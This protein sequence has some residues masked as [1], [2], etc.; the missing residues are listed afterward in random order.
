MGYGKS[1]SIIYKYRL[2]RNHSNQLLGP[3]TEVPFV[4]S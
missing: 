2:G 3:T 1:I 4:Q